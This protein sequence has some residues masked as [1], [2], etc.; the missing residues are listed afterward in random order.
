MPTSPIMITR[1]STATVISTLNTLGNISGIGSFGIQGTRGIPTRIPIRTPTF[2]PL[3][4]FPIV[5][6]WP[7]ESP[8]A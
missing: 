6:S 8:A 7:L 5:S 4:R 2:P 3:V 1:T